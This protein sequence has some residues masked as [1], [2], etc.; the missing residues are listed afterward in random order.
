MPCSDSLPAEFLLRLEKIVAPPN[1]AGV[2]GSFAEVKTTTVRVNTLKT[3]VSRVLEQLTAAGITCQAATDSIP[4]ALLVPWADRDRL[5]RLP[6]VENGHI[7]I[8]GLAS[9]LATRVLDPQ[10]GE[11]VLDLAAAPGGKATHIA[12]QMQNQ[13][14]L[15][16]VEPIRKRM[17]V[18]ADIL[19]RYGVTIAKTYLID[20]R[21][22]G[23]KTPNRF[24]RVLLDAPCSGEAMFRTGQP[25]TWRYWSLRKIAEQSRK[26]LGLIKSAFLSLKP[27]GVLLY[28]TCSFA[29]EENESIVSRLLEQ[30]PGNAELKPIELP[31]ENW[32]PGLTEF[33]SQRWPAA[34]SECRRLL[35]D[36]NVDAF[37]LAKILK[38]EPTR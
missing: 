36:R 9:V 8:Q 11:W 37:F 16:V 24:D 5:T 32:Q 34:M 21:K 25:E 7:F 13:G 3:T 6:H 2:V 38:N 27:G 28:G 35:P 14:K 29:P 22:V 30:F 20:G 19:K 12:Q 1:Q 31:I 33:E 18:L 4:E 10:P 15:S 23:G 17:F 26:Q